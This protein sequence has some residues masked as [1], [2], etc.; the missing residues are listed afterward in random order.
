MSQS[1]ERDIWDAVDEI[2]Q[3]T[4][5]DPDPVSMMTDGE[6]VRRS[7]LSVVVLRGR[8]VIEMFRQWAERNNIYERQRDI[9]GSFRQAFEGGDEGLAAAFRVLER[10]PNLDLAHAE[11]ERLKYDAD[12]ET[13]CTH[14]DHTRVCNK[15]G[16]VAATLRRSDGSMRC[17][18]GHPTRWCEV[19]ERDAAVTA[20]RKRILDE[21]YFNTATGALLSP[22]QWAEV[23]EAILTK[24]AVAASKEP[25]HG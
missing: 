1:D 19:S 10:V 21:I 22:K 20:E 17:A 14:P 8:A 7:D 4:A 24:E 16:C 9:D 15:P 2:C 13:V 3:H 23:K 5:G 11:Q 12:E 18:A 6:D 25:G